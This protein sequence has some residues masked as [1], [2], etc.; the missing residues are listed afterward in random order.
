MYQVP[1]T[2]SLFSFILTTQNER[3]LWNYKWENRDFQKLNSLGKLKIEEVAEAGWSILSTLD[4][5]LLVK[6][7]F[8]SHQI[9]KMKLLINFWGC[10]SVQ[11]VDPSRGSW[12]NQTSH[13]PQTLNNQGTSMS[14]TGV[15][16]IKNTA[17]TPDCLSLN[18]DSTSLCI[19]ET[20]DNV[21]YFSVP[22]FLHV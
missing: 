17:I 5:G 1:S 14:T 3:L 19:L 7:I 21:L 18:L 16:S 4:T 9:I 15:Q 12:E 8:Q 22:Q 6:D 2:C 11:F 13:C 10:S 20:L